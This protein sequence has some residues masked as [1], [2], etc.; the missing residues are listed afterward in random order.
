MAE[1]KNFTL[2]GKVIDYLDKIMELLGKNDYGYAIGL[3]I[4][5]LLKVMQEVVHNNGT[6]IIRFP[7]GKEEILIQPSDEK[8]LKPILR[9]VK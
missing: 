1:S 2:N 7:D 4:T 5:M 3:A 8:P 6:A 9:L